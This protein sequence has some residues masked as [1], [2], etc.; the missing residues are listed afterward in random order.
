[1]RCKLTEIA[2]MYYGPY[3]KGHIKGNIKYLVS[4]HFDDFH[5]PTNFKDSYINEF[6]DMEKYLLQPNDVIYTGKGQRI[7]AWAYN[8]EYG[9]VVPSSLFYIIKIKNT[10]LLIGEYL[11]C[12]LNTDKIYNKLKSISA[13]TSIPSIQKS[14]LEQLTIPIPPIEEQ[15]RIVEFSNL[16]DKDVALT[17]Q[18]LEK[19]KALKKGLLNRVINDKNA[20][21]D[22]TK[23]P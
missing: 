22:K 7:F 5:K 1:M 21:A 15:R 20:F 19:K 4:S 2:T 10:E 11:A 18:L 17:T 13:G 6:E 14:E 23:K 12:F 9:K 3:E 16:M 8:S